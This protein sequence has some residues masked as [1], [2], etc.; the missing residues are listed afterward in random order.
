M[1]SPGP[2]PCPAC[3]AREGNPTGSVDGYSMRRCTVCGTHFA[4]QVPGDTGLDYSGYYHAGNL[5][6]PEVVHRQ[7]DRIVE[8]FDGQRQTNRWLDVGC[9]AGALLLACHKHG[10][11]A[12]GTEIS[13]RPVEALR[14][15]G[16]DA[17]LGNVDSL[18]LPAA[19]F[20]VVSM[21]EVIEH[22][23]EPRRLLEAV[24]VLLRPGGTLYVTTPNSRGLSARLLGLR[25]SVV[26]PPEH[27]QL[28]SRQGLR[29]AVEGAG[30]VA[31]SL[32]T[33]GTNPSEIASA[34]RRKPPVNGRTRVD[35]AYRLNAS[36]SSNRAGLALKGAV[37][38]VLDLTRLG[39]GLKLTA[40]R[41]G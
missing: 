31:H 29:M 13:A 33:H 11:D 14:A 32:H 17:R 35:S 12:T 37:N 6:V 41:P 39:D 4:E 23:P 28:F 26:S 5:E 9:G 36:L 34:L 19:T 10:W 22:V 8:S 38:A 15:R 20:D 1:T 40:A 25:W 30:M 21:V 18:D 3:G 7:L 2:R 24:G 16:L 27:L